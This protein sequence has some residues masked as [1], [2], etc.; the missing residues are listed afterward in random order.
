MKIVIILFTIFLTSCSLINFLNTHKDKT[1]SINYDQLYCTEKYDHLNLIAE[2]KE[3]FNFY[4]DQPKLVPSQFNII[5]AGI[6]YTLSEMIR[7]PDLIGPQSR[8]QLFLKKDNTEYYFDIRPK[9][10]EEFE[11]PSLLFALNFLNKKFNNKNYD[12][13]LKHLD[14]NLNQELIVSENFSK[15]LSSLKKELSKNDYLYDTFFKGDEILTK[16]ETFTRYNFLENFNTSKLSSKLKTNAYITD[17]SVIL[18]QKLPYKCNFAINESDSFHR[19]YPKNDNEK[20]LTISLT[21]KNDVFLAVVSSHIKQ[22]LSPYSNTV[23]NFKASSPILA[24]PFC[25]FENKNSTTVVFSLKDTNA[26]QFLHNLKDYG[27]DEV[28][29]HQGLNKTLNF[30]RHLFLNSPDRIL[31]ESKKARSKQLDEF[32]KLNIPIY[33]VNNLGLLNSWA[34]IKST[35]QIHSLHIDSRSNNVMSCNQ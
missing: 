30:S 28:T 7:R 17:E 26:H 23:Y 25:K 19:N 2:N 34:E 35:K 24:V 3:V 21:K 32:L 1:T 15:S 6:I 11:N 9:N 14:N 12:Y 22:P 33:H 4:K 16:F 18:N 29:D 8:I 13:I 27:I 20:N 31:L 10:L 5:E